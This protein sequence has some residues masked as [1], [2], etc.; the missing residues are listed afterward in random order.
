MPQGFN[1]SDDSEGERRLMAQMHKAITIIQFK[2]EAQ[3]IR[4]R[5]EYGL[6]DRLLLDKIDFERGTVRIDERIYPSA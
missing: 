6:E 3:I 4:R 5:P 2:L 1:Q